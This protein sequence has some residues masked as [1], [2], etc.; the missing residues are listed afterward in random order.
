[1]FGVAFGCD[2]LLFYLI[3]GLNTSYRRPF[4]NTQ[5]NLFH[6]GITPNCPA[7]TNGCPTPNAVFLIIEY[8]IVQALL[9]DR[10][11]P[12]NLFGKPYLFGYIASFGEK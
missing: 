11:Q 5:M 12:T 7:F 9:Y 8:G 4:K 2:A 3:F 1:L 6:S 10:T